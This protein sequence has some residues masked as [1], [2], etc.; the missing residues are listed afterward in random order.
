MALEPLEMTTDIVCAP[1][2]K[3]ETKQGVAAVQ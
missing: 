3:I 1:N 2:V